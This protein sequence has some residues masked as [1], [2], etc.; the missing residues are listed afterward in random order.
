L[1]FLL[2]FVDSGLKRITAVQAER[3]HQAGAVSG[4][5]YFVI[6]ITDRFQF[7][8]QWVVGTS[9]RRHNV[10]LLYGWC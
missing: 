7:S 2:F 9:G 8:Q 5:I 4:L 10:H 6:C 1:T 3:H